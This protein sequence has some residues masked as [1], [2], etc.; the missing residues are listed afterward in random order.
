MVDR[1]VVRDL[2][3][4]ARELELGPVAI[5]VVEHLDE[6]VLRQVFGHFPVA[7]HPEDQ[8]EDGPLVS[9]H[10]LS[11]CRL[12]PFLRERGDVGIR[13]IAEIESEGHSVGEKETAR[14]I[15]LLARKLRRAL[16]VS[17]HE[18][19]QRLRALYAPGTFR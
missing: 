1:D 3:Q 18:H 10:Q 9:P 19:A 13:K 4:P 6:G 5:D 11:K 7:H 8:R 17:Q 15:S 12:A 16:G 14:N 2:E